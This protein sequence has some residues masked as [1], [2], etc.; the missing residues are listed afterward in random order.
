VRFFTF[1]FDICPLPFGFLLR[2]RCATLACQHKKKGPIPVIGMGPEI[3]RTNLQ[4]TSKNT[5]ESIHFE[6]PGGIS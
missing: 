1:A 5:V 6:N 4:V 3:G 2:L